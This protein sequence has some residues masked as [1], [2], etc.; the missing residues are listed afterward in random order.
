MMA[1]YYLVGDVPVQVDIDE[2]GVWLVA[3]N[4]VMGGYI[5]D[6]QYYRMLKF[7]RGDNVIEVSYIEY[8][9][10]ILYLSEKYSVAHEIPQEEVE[11]IIELERNN[12]GA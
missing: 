11:K 6:P 10:Q 5:A 1:K 4:P 12:N 9:R 7:N 8:Q 3:F 2:D